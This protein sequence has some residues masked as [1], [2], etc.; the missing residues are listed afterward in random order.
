MILTGLAVGAVLGIVMQRGR[1]CVTGMLR[2]IFLQKTWRSFVALLIVISVHAVGIAALTSAGVIAP[3]YSNF[4][5]LA[6][7]GGGFLFG[8]GIILTG[9]CASGTWFRSAEG[10]VGSWIA[11]IFYA[12]SASAMQT[13]ALNW[14]N[15]GV[16]SYDTSLTTLPASFGVSVWFFAVPLAIGTALAARHFL[17]KEA[18]QPKVARL[19][20]PWWRRPLHIYTAGALVGLIG[21]IAWP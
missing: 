8:L 2:D 10:L 17:A 3:T 1:F 14:L 11:L 5:P 13:G 7:I 12:L 4:A 20:G 15:A 21:V 18:T 16:K 9:G 6:V 19:N